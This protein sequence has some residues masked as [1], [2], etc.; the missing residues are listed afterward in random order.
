MV[1]YVASATV[2]KPVKRAQKLFLEFFSYQTPGCGDRVASVGEENLLIE[3]Q[4][5]RERHDP[6]RKGETVRSQ[7][8]V[9]RS[10]TTRQLG[11]STACFQ[12]NVKAA[13][14]KFPVTR[15]SK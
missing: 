7:A 8:I 1:D 3:R 6:P 4:G 15:A 13:K 11:Y 10:V 9:T 12:P 2:R 5:W 14:S